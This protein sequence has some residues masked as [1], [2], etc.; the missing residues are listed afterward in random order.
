MNGTNQNQSLEKSELRYYF[1]RL[2]IR[3]FILF[4][5]TAQFTFH[6]QFTICIHTNY[7]QHTLIFPILLIILFL[8]FFILSSEKFISIIHISFSFV[9]SEWFQVGLFSLM[10]KSLHDIPT[11]EYIHICILA[12]T[13]YIPSS[14]IHGNSLHILPL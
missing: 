11:Q 7:S 8:F 2:T 14:S 5:H 13:L 12:L 9:S 10:E 6:T 4:N 1:I 3:N